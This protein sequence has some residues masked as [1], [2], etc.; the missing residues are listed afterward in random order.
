MAAGRLA[1]L[2]LALGSVV[3]V[4]AETVT[5]SL[6]IRQARWELRPGL[7]TTAWSYNGVVPG[8]PIVARV[9][10]RLVV[11]ARNRLHVA[12]NIHWHG[13]EVPN[14]Q[15]GPGA[16]IEPG[17]G[18]RFEFTLQRTG[19]YWYHSHYMPVLPQLDRGLYGP[20]V[21]LAPEDAAYTADHV[22]VLDDWLLDASGRRLEGT[23]SG[24]M[25][26]LG[27]VETVNGKTGDAI[28]PLS[29]T[30]GGLYKLRFVNASTAA[31]HTLG[32]SGH[33]FR[34]THL[35]GHGVARPWLA[36][37][38]TL[39]PGER[40]DVEVE[41]GG[42]SGGSYAIE[43]DRPRLGIRIPIR[44]AGGSMAAVASPYRPPAP[45]APPGILERAADHVLVL[46]S[47]MGMM[48]G[49]MMG[50]GMSSMMRWTING[51]SFPETE[52]LFVKVGELVK[53]RFVNRDT[54]MMHPMD[55]PIH[56]HGTRFLLVAVNGTPPDQELW[57]D[58][59]S[60]PAGGSVDMA[61]AMPLP[62]EWM[63]HCHII[64]HEDGGMMTVV[65]A[66]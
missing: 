14:E 64:D 7:A 2:L 16:A 17:A 32:I 35:D 54:G 51:L 12:T 11:E 49:G 45:S 9:G 38:V 5:V 59:V 4:S 41:A 24:D 15:D 58:T 40:I 37:T 66:E 10:D 36:D 29:F 43:S 20:L 30:A 27:N 8:T 28:A 34:V 22:L 23:G 26:R 25:E 46:D 3:A 56:L 42:R 13:L 57:K 31:V 53:V 63:L 21:V 6:D 65:I 50:G 60:V 47:A 18:R 1:A 52:P 62:G 48:G 33:R 44:Y 55:H 19:T 39:S 61:F